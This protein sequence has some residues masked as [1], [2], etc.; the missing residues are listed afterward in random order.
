L[1]HL[2][3]SVDEGHLPI[4]AAARIREFAVIF[5]ERVGDYS[6]DGVIRAPK[7]FALFWSMR[8]VRAAF[9]LPFLKVEE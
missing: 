3:D 8:R 6:R 1:I 5:A 2:T 4:Y 9:R 7:F